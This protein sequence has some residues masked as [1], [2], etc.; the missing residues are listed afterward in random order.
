MNARLLTLGT[1][2]V[3]ATATAVPSQARCARTHLRMGRSRDVP[4]SFATQLTGPALDPMLA[5]R[6][7]NQFKMR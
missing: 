5:V 6:L 4:R 2:H 1:S 7:C 3:Q